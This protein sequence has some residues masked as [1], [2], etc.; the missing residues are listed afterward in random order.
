VRAPAGASKEDDVTLEEQASAP[1]TRAE[2]EGFLTD[3][4]HSLDAEPDHWDNDNLALFLDAMHAW[5]VDMDGYFLGRGEALP[6]EASWQLFAQILLA[7]RV[8]E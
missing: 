8:Y 1:M 3:F 4:V 7:A 2:F 6:V 5:V